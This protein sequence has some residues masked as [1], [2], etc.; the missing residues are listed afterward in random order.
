[1]SDETKSVGRTREEITN[2][3][4]QTLARS[5]EILY[6]FLKQ[7]APFVESVD[8]LQNEARILKETEDA[9]QPAQ[10]ENNEP[11]DK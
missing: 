8:K 6:T 11:T 5:G 4:V 1:M 7:L 2:E 10:V 3:Y 9:E